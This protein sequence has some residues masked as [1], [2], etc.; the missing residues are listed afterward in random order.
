MT[1]RKA[2]LQQKLK[3]VPKNPGVYIMYDA[4]GSVIYVGKAIKLKNRLQCYFGDNRSQPSLK[5]AMM[6]AKIY[7]FQYIIC[8]NEQ[9]ALILESNLIKRHQPFYNILLKD[10]HDYPYIKVSLNESWPRV[11]KAYRVGSDRAFG[12]KYYG[13]YLNSQ[14]Q[15]ALR[16][17]EQIFPLASCDP[18]KLKRFVPCLNYQ[19]GKCIG[20]CCKVATRDDYLKVIERVCKY[21]N[22]DTQGVLSYLTEAMNEAASQGKFEQAA[23][24]RDRLFALKAL[25]ATQRIVS[26]QAIDLDVL[27]ICQQNLLYC[28]Q[29]L[30]IRQGKITGAS[31]F[32]I[33]VEDL[34]Y[35]L[36][37]SD[38][39]LPDVDASSNMQTDKAISKE[40]ALLP[41]KS[42]GSLASLTEDEQSVTALLELFFS[43]HYAEIDNKPPNILLANSLNESILAQLKRDFIAITGQKCNFEQAKRG[44]RYEWGKLALNNAREALS[45]KLLMLGSKISNR[46]TALLSLQKLNNLKTIPHR[47]E[48]YDVANL[49]NDDLCAAMVC[50]I[51]GVY[52][53]K[54]SLLFK[55]PNQNQQ[56]DYLAMS[57]VL[58]RRLKHLATLEAVNSLAKPGAMELLKKADNLE[59]EPDLILL[60]GGRGHQQAVLKALEQNFNWSRQSI[61]KRLKIAGMV[62]NDKHETRALLTAEGEQLE[63]MPALNVERKGTDIFLTSQNGT[64]QSTEEAVNLLRL[65]TKVQD[66]VHRL[67]NDYYRKLQKKRILHYELQDIPGIGPKKCQLLLK[68]F[69]STEA[70]KLASVAE[71]EQVK[72]IS[73]N[74]AEQIYEYYRLRQ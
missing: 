36:F 24:F 30:E 33:S 26:Q 10:D 23:F 63:L 48:A 67:A 9:E 1:K 68:H 32:F 16:S 14:L 20:T 69:K 25:H 60:D 17:L 66:E 45:K 58:V 29:K 5:V 62:K 65:L 37:G 2:Y 49:G 15:M 41:N 38:E 40:V 8:Q 42:T 74:N 53:P 61:S 19:I 6:I 50:F 44:E 3:L 57:T 70:V 71:L 7:D 64:K 39:K 34:S 55:L 73:H 47:I 12:A 52:T 22:G 4:K 35:S 46:E 59:S 51:D 54:N 21:L 31:N 18:S 28:I 56:D 43:Q 27:A 13:P 11:T 72:G